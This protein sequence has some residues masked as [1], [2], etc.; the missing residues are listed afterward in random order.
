MVFK[1]N[2]KLIDLTSYCVTV[3]SQHGYIILKLELQYLGQSDGQGTLRTEVNN[4]AFRHRALANGMSLNPRTFVPI[5]SVACTSFSSDPTSACYMAELCASKD[6][7]K[8]NIGLIVALSI[9]CI[10]VLFETALIAYN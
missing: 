6:E 4:N 9:I 8:Q 2:G 3:V 10:V 7:C 1:S 5:K